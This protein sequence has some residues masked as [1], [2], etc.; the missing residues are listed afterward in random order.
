MEL[1]LAVISA[2]TGL[3]SLILFWDKLKKIFQ[4]LFNKIIKKENYMSTKKIGD[5]F[6]IQSDA[7]KIDVLFFQFGLRKNIPI[8]DYLYLKYIDEFVRE[9]KISK[10]FI[11]PT[12]KTTND[13]EIDSNFEIFKRNIK[14]ILPNHN[15][16]FIKPYKKNGFEEIRF[17]EKFF[18][19]LDY[20]DSPEF[21]N[22]IKENF[23]MKVKSIKDFD[24]RKTGKILKPTFSHIRETME[25]VYRIKEYL[26]T[27]GNKKKVATIFWER[28]I[29]SIGVYRHFAMHEIIKIESTIIF[30]K[31]IMLNRKEP[32]PTQDEQKSIGMFDDKDT[33]IS[34]LESQNVEKYIPLLKSIVNAYDQNV[35]Y[36][37]IRSKGKEHCN[38]IENK[39]IKKERK[40]YD[41][42]GLMMKIKE[43]NDL[44]MIDNI[45]DL[46]SHYYLNRCFFFLPN[47]CNASCKFCHYKPIKVNEAEI[48]K[49]IINNAQNIIHILKTLG[50]NEFRF[51]GGEPLL[52]EN[53]DKLLDLV[54]GDQ[55][56]YT[57]LTNGI[58]LNNYLNYFET[59]KPKKI[60]ISY[61]S[62]EKYKEIFGVDY[63]SEHLDENIK[64]IIQMKIP[65]TVTI[66]FLKENSEEIIE[67][68]EHLKSL[69][70]DSIKIIYPNTSSIGKT[71]EEEF[72]KI[73]SRI[74][75]NT[76]LRYSNF[77]NEN[78]ELSNKGYLSYFSQKKSFS[79][80]S[81]L[82]P[83]KKGIQSSQKNIEKILWDFYFHSETIKDIPCKSHIKSC[84]LACENS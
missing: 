13:N 2:I 28:E 68:I 8:I 48:E 58:L 76:S 46:V 14:K 19:V 1:F 20:L 45:T 55:V 52:F 22:Y 69:G 25:L 42:M 59:N 70:V 65:L 47:N 40:F 33:I 18:D 80:C 21:Y 23:S 71:M 50:F 79:E 64:K 84:P 32:I 24:H 5:Y 44:K 41:T 16:E 60:T 10:I 54:K 6:R 75:K 72:N 31:T 35:D 43:D 4:D 56:S 11:L 17:K 26:G 7:K 36:N 15:I 73:I 37:K 83:T 62:K 81:N 61:H 49:T 30:G 38:A 39:T 63:E 3:I 29:D 78:C 9:R 67:H 82:I 66:V 12:V 57:I 74:P 27:N 77:K 51:T 53:F 34:K